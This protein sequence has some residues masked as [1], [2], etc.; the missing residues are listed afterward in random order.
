MV[1][2]KYGEVYIM[3]LLIRRV[4]KKNK[5]RHIGRAL[6][7]RYRLFNNRKRWFEYLRLVS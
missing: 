4:I 5:T 3:K 2:F 7:Y 1:R 6:Q